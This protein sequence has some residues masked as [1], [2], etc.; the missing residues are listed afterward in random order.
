MKLVQ[1]AAASLGQGGPA[2]G[3]VGGVVAATAGKLRMSSV[4]Y[5]QDNGDVPPAS[6]QLGRV[7][8]LC[9]V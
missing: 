9:Q 1:Q 3:G 8:R 7:R 6:P 5:V 2:K 4:I